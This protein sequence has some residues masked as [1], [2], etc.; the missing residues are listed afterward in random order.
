M[1][2]MEGIQSKYGEFVCRS[3]GEVDEC[4]FIY[5]DLKMAGCGHMLIKVFSSVI[6][7]TQYQIK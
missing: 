4:A 1:M 5:V 3:E 6:Y 7:K 2:K